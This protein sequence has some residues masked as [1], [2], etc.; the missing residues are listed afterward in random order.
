MN[1]RSVWI[2]IIVII[3]LALGFLAYSMSNDGTGPSETATATDSTPTTTDTN[4]PPE[5]NTPSPVTITYNGSS[6]SPAN[7]SVPVGTTVTWVNPSNDRMWIASNDHPTHTRYDGTATSEHCANGTATSASVFDQCDA[8]TQYSFT[9]TKTGTWGYHN[10]S[11]SGAR[12][13]VIVE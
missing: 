8:G 6:F 4:P 1:T 13:T 11:N 3:I 9:F 7:V 2:V 10:H 5:G 12:G